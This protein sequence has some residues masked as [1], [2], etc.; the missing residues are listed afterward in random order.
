MKYQKTFMSVLCLFVIFCGT[1]MADGFEG[2]LNIDAYLVNSETYSFSVTGYLPA[3]M[4]AILIYT[5]PDREVFAAII[6]RDASVAATEFIDSLTPFYSVVIDLQNI[7][8]DAYLPYILQD[9]F[10]FSFYTVSSDESFR[11]ESFRDDVS[12][13]FRGTSYTQSLEIFSISYIG[14]RH[15]RGCFSFG[16]CGNGPEFVGPYCDPCVTTTCCYGDWG[17]ITCGYVV[18]HGK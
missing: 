3:S 11:D 5:E 16:K 12:L 10:G 6:S 17:Y 14:A 1:V 15:D 4:D 9:S 13:T 7:D 2:E 8:I 18:C